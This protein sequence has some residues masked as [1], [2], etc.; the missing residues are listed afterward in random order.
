MNRQQLSQKAIDEFKAIYHQEFGESLSDDEVHE[1]ALR[2]LRFFGI[3]LDGEKRKP[4][5]NPSV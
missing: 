2:L 1:I 4:P 3:L 5:S